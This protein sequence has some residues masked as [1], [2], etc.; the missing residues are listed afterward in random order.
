MQKKTCLGGSP[1]SYSSPCSLVG[2]TPLLASVGGARR[3]LVASPTCA[4]WHDMV[5][6]LRGSLLSLLIFLCD[7]C[8][9]AVML[10]PYVLIWIRYFTQWFYP[11]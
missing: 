6:Y 2:S 9:V 7:V 5:T 10:L 4:A 8:L 11:V 3:A 1:L